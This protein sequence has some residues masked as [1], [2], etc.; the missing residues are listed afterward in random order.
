MHKLALRK[1]NWP[2]PAARQRLLE[3]VESRQKV[4][5]KLASLVA[6]ARIL[7]PPKA[8]LEQS[9]DERVALYRA[10]RFS[11]SRVADITAGFGIDF[12]ALAQKA[13]LGVYV[14]PDAWLQALAT[15]NLPLLVPAHLQLEACTA[16]EYLARQAP[17]SLDL[18]FCDPSRRS[19]GRRVAGFE[20]CSPNILALLPRA[21]EIAPVLVIKASPML[22]VTAGCQQLA[23]HVALVLVIALHGEVKEVCFVCRRGQHQP[24]F[25]A[26]DLVDNLAYSTSE[27]DPGGALPA[28]AE[29]QAY[30]YEPSSA[31]LKAGLAD[32]LAAHA[33]LAKLHRNTHLFTHQELKGHWQGRVHQILGILPASGKGLDEMLSARAARVAVRNFPQTADELRKKLKLKEDD[34]HTVMACQTLE[35]YRL[36]VLKKVLAFGV[37]VQAGADLLE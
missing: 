20:D 26:I 35:G 6:D 10:S 5:Q 1:E 2:S 21:L 13:E 8:N 16:E 18:I 31:V 28:L 9:S 7:F 29:P 30:L 19:E 12:I 27:M 3:Q 24:L 14:E 32:A 25:E 11:G 17:N 15:H 33:G 34:Q 22:D 4:A 36:L 23:P 37:D